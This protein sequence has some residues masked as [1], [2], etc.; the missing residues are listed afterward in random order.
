MHRNYTQHNLCCIIHKQAQETPQ[1]PKHSQKHENPLY[2]KRLVLF[3]FCGYLLWTP[4]PLKSWRKCPEIQKITWSH[5]IPLC[6]KT[7]FQW[8]RGHADQYWQRNRMF[9]VAS[10]KKK[11]YWEPKR[12]GLPKK[13]RECS[14]SLSVWTRNHQK[15]LGE[16]QEQLA[17]ARGP[18]GHIFPFLGQ[19]L[20]TA[21]HHISSTN[22]P[23]F[24]R[25]TIAF[26]QETPPRIR[27]LRDGDSGYPWNGLPLCEN[28]CTQ[29]T[30]GAYKEG[31]RLLRRTSSNRH[32]CR[33]LR[34]P[35]LRPQRLQTL[36]QLSCK[37]IYHSHDGQVRFHFTDASIMGET[38]QDWNS[39]K[40]KKKTITKKTIKRITERD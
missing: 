12:N 26:K 21:A 3:S 36:R 16:F 6:L 25:S 15:L 18:N 7:V 4:A 34:L 39:T 19:N 31:K 5:M 11:K 27:R 10:P 23:N 30:H 29:Q 33:R 14:R 13:A 8:F 20:G 22:P 32:K 38:T 1:H 35:E 28:A 40:V 24:K 2:R 37:K 9:H 17:S